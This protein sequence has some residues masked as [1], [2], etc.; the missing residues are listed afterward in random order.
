MNKFIVSICFYWPL[1]CS[2]L[3]IQNWVASFISI[4]MAQ[5]IAYSNVSLIILGVF[6]L[7][8]NVGQ[9]SQTNKIW[10]IFYLIYYCFALLASGINGFISPIIAS[11][12]APVY[13]VG[14]YFLLS[15][16]YQFKL[17]SK[18]LTIL[19]VISSIFTIYLFKINFSFDNSG[20]LAWNLDRAEGL[21]G[22]ANNAALSSIIAYILF[23]N[24]YNPSKLFF[25]VIKILILITLFYSLF[26]TFSTTGLFAFVIIFYITNY[27]FFTGIRFVFFGVAIVLFYV[28]I[29]TIKSQTSNLDLSRAQI[30]KID[31][32]INVLTLNVEDVDNSGRGDLIENIMHYLYENPILGNGIGF[33]VVLRGHNT[34]IG[35]WVDAGIFAF[36]FFLFVLLIYL[37]KTLTLDLHLRFFS[38]SLLVVLYI[39]MVS[40]QT[41]L[42]QPY[43]IVLFVFIG[44]IIDYNKLHHQDTFKIT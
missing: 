2:S 35:I 5:V 17:F 38:I 31:N 12:I 21:Y 20:I 4:N 28:G 11:L 6:L 33:S 9:L 44:Y 30:V 36:L 25:R 26:I 15:D 16:P 7:K 27:K 42:N 23:D 34:Y 41:V 22:D 24:F 32:I 14:F 10:L 3:N 39:F 18:I 29:F 1:F 43:L 19:F 8:R 37:L 40:L 13:F